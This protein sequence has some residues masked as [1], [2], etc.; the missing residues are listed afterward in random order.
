MA[1]VNSDIAV[2]Q[3]EF[4]A[5][6]L[7]PNELGGRVRVV[8]G[9]YAPAAA[10]A[11]GTVIRLA[12]IPKGSRLLNMS[13][14]Y[15]EAGQGATTTFKFGDELDDDR[16]FAAAAPGAGAV[17]KALDANILSPYVFAQ[18]MFVIATTGVAALTAGKKIAFELYYVI[19]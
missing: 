12:R 2:K 6:K 7:M 14:V 17:S 19:D 11:A 15:F 3:T 16:Y 9:V 1:T 18:E 8:R 4:G 10:D 13:K 5:S